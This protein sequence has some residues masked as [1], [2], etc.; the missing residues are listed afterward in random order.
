MIEVSSIDTLD[1]PDVALILPN[2]AVDVD[3]ITD[4]GELDVHLAGELR[5]QLTASTTRK[6]A[7]L[8]VLQKKSARCHFYVYK[9]IAGPTHSQEAS[10]LI[11][12]D[13]LRRT[14]DDEVT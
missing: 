9:D 3:S 11:G 5:P 6:I 1:R 2:A 10:N 12:A 14:R 7:A 8:Q 4:V 13:I